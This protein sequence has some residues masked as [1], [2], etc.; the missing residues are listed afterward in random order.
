MSAHSAM[1]YDYDILKWQTTNEWDIKCLILTNARTLKPQSPK[2]L[3]I[4]SLR[5]SGQDWERQEIW[6]TVSKVVE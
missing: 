2:H 4:K 1:Y 3:M 5:R 6:K